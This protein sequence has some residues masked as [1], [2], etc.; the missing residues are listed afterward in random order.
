MKLSETAEVLA[1]VQSFNNRTVGE[2]DVIAWRSVLSDV[3]VADAEEAVRRY[4]AEETDWI[5]PAHVRRLVRDIV[6]EREV[7]AQATGWAPG[8]AGVPK[9][10]AMPEVAGP[11]D[12]NALTPSVRALLESVRAMLP[13]GSREAL[14]PRTVAWEREH[15]A[16]TRTRD[17]EPNPLYRPRATEEDVTVRTTGPCGYF[18]HPSVSHVCAWGAVPYPASYY[19]AKAEARRDSDGFC[20][21]GAGCAHDH[22]ESEARCCSDPACRCEPGECAC[23]E[24]SCGA[25]TPDGPCHLRPGHPVGPMWP[26]YGGHIAAEARRDWQGPPECVVTGDGQCQTHGVHISSCPA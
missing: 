3:D 22:R 25:S 4:Y 26:G 5:M 12:E 15:A 14:M 18:G 6:R 20:T 7:V 13:E 1:L 8:Q 9:D 23:G 10:Q 19:D 17:A 24:Q 11:V 21:G 16:F 2:K